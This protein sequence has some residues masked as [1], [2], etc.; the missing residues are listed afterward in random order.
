MSKMNVKP[1]KEL[2]SILPQMKQWMEAMHQDPELSAQEVN[3]GK[4]VA[5]LLKNMGYEVHEH[6]GKQ[7]IE[8]VVGVLSHG[9]GKKK[10]GIRADMDALP[11]QE[12]NNLPY[13]SRHDGISHL[14]GHDG[15][16]AMALGA[17][18]YL[19]D[20]K[21]FNGTVYFYFQPAEETMQ[22]GPSMIDD[23]L[24]SGFKRI[25]YAGGYG[26]KSIEP[27]LTIKWMEFLQKNSTIQRIKNGLKDAK[28]I[29][30]FI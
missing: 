19:A 12:I 6:V 1:I 21:H 23:G 29:T 20:T 24:I 3:T 18:K 28:D 2:A 22:G 13:K 26:F 16:S 9:D 14:C 7:G 30:P 11:I 17:A 15:H 4:Y 27:R 8:G 10:I 5:D 25:S